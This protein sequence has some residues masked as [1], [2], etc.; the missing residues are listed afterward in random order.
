MNQTTTKVSTQPTQFAIP[1]DSADGGQ[2]IA[3]AL[4]DHLFGHCC[5]RRVMLFEK[6]GQR[7][8]MLFK[9]ER[10]VPV[11][12]TFG[13]EVCAKISVIRADGSGTWFRNVGLW[14]RKAIPE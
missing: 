12:V 1:A 2:Y 9:S 14:M 3:P 11:T 5:A 7:Y 10:L 8:A 13:I 6:G 4:G